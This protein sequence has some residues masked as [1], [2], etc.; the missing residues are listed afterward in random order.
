MPPNLLWFSLIS[1]SVDIQKLKS[2]HLGVC[3]QLL[4]AQS[5]Y[6]NAIAS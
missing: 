1:I 6:K 5:E 4:A 2:H 3:I